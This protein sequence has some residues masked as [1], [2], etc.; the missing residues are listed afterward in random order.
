MSLTNIALNSRSLNGIVTISDGVAVLT[1]GNLVCEDINSNSLTTNNLNANLLTISGKLEC[2]LAGPYTIPISISSITGLLISYG[3]VSN[4]GSTDFTNFG[5]IYTTTQQGF[6]FFNKSNV[7]TLTN[8]AIIDN[9]QTYFSSPLTGVTCET[10]IAG[11]SVV[12]K[13]YVDNNF[14]FKTNNIQESINGYKIFSNRVD[15]NGGTAL[16]V[17]TG[18]SLFNGVVTFGSTLTTNNLTADLVAGTQNIYTNNTTG[19]IN[20][21]TGM[22]TGTLNLG[23]ST[24]ST[25]IKSVLTIFD[26][27]TP[28]TNTLQIH[29]TGANA[30][31][32]SYAGPT[33][34]TNHIFTTYNTTNTAKNSLTIN[35]SSITINDTTIFNARAIRSTSPATTTNVFF[36]NM[37]TGSLTLG[38][39]TSFIIN[40]STTT[41]NRQNTFNNFAPISNIS[42]TISTHLTTKNYTDITFQTIANMVNYVDISTAQSISGVKTFLNRVNC[43]GTT[44]LVVAGLAQ[45]NGITEFFSTT[46]FNNSAP[47]CSVIASSNSDL[48]NK[49]YVDNAVSGSSLL[50]TNNT[51]TG[52]NLFNNAVSMANTLTFSA[53]TININSSTTT[54]ATNLFSLITTGTQSLWSNLSN[55][56]V[57]NFF[58]SATSDVNLNINAKVKFRQVKLYNQV[59]NVSITTTLTFP[60]EE[61]ILI[62][63]ASNLTTTLPVIT[64]NSL[65][66]TFNFIKNNLLRTHTFTA[67][68][69]DTIVKNGS[70]SGL[71]SQVLM[72]D[73]ITS[74][75]LV[76]LEMVSGSGLYNWVVVNSSLPQTISNPIGSIIQMSVNI[77]PAGYLLCDGTSY[78]TSSY[79]ALF[80]IIGYTY[81]GAPTSTYK[82]PDF[83]GIFLRGYGINGANAN[84]VSSSIGVIQNDTIKAH[85]HDFTFQVPN[86]ISGGGSSRACEIS[87]S[88]YATTIST[89]NQSIDAETK[90]ANY[91]VIYFI[92]Y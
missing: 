4:S 59:K 91:A 86:N 55:N 43:N 26:K 38:S 25:N 12:N 63:S 16:I 35:N 80:N 36:D 50:T 83:R 70:I 56:S 33:T 67:Q 65:G 89:Q 2:N 18:T 52:T 39:L 45:F 41:L 73:G 9:S 6:R 84:Y 82:V 51:W 27:N 48:T 71:T 8:L 42:P 22:T 66:L 92:K 32:I 87:T 79:V 54:H 24:S 20:L 29:Q 31:Y 1:E 88:G 30:T 78:S 11:T 76:I 40:N 34:S 61:N 47:I 77:T 85:S 28:F 60:L 49:L 69:S 19:I 81:G 3:N 7:Q 37:T 15:L 21:G 17:G 53:A 57:V 5:S 10:P 13:S 58:S 75:Q 68:G 64:T 23:T 46:T 62:N 90:P 14:M 44:A 72:D 74:F